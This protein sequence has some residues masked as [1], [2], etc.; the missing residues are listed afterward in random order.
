MI[1]QNDHG[2]FEERKFIWIYSSGEFRVHQG[3][4]EWQQPAGKVSKQQELEAKSSPCKT[5]G[6]K[7]RE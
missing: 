1:K 4:K 5:G 3:G 7:Q 6:I 2:N